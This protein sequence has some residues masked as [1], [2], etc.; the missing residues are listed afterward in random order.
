MMYKA[1]GAEP[2]FVYAPTWIFD[3]IINGLQFLADKT[4]SE[5]WEDAAETGRIGKYY[6]VE[7]ML[8]TD[9]TEKYGKI[10]MQDHF[11]KIASKGQD[12]FTP[13]RATAVIGRVLESLPTALSFAI[14]ALYVVSHPQPALG[15]G[16]LDF[17]LIL[18]SLTDHI[19]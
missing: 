4:Q 6:A 16:G 3:Y 2:K 8:T 19:S 17:S 14:P 15:A 9:P 13:V 12:P 18:S 7:D 1:I 5:A 11:N 10:T